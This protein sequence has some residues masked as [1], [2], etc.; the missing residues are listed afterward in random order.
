LFSHV[1]AAAP[2]TTLPELST[3]IDSRHLHHHHQQQHYSHDINPIT[4]N[5]TNRI[6]L[7]LKGDDSNRFDLVAATTNHLLPSI[8]G[9]LFSKA[10]FNGP[11]NGLHHRRRA[12]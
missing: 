8:E 12:A 5:K 1:A 10:N 7:R 9:S 6:G 4:T 2:T 11:E 3:H